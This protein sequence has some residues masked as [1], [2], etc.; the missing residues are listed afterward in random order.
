MQCATDTRFTVYSCESVS[1]V[2][3][4]VDCMLHMDPPCGITGDHSEATD[5]KYYTTN[6][7]RNWAHM[8]RLD[9]WTS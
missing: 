7:N 1:N 3:Q 5:F 8:L 9:Y 4:G 2:Y 6:S